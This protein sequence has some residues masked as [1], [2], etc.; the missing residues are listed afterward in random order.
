[1]IRIHF[2]YKGELIHRNTTPGYALRYWCLHSKGGQL[3]ANT[4]KGMKELINNRK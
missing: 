3:C 2:E 4:Q 1:M